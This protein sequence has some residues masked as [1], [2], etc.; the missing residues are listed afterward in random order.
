MRVFGP[1]AASRGRACGESRKAR[2]V[3]GIGA[4]PRQ[5]RLRYVLSAAKDGSRAPRRKTTTVYVVQYEPD[6]HHDI[7]LDQADGE[8]PTLAA[9]RRY[10]TTDDPAPLRIVRRRETVIEPPARPH[11]PVIHMRQ[12]RNEAVTV[13]TVHLTVYHNHERLL[14][15]YADGHRLHAVTSHTLDIHPVVDLDETIDAVAEWAWRTFNADL[16][17]LQNDRIDSRGETTFFAAAVYRLLGNR[18]L[19]AGDILHLHIADR[20]IWLACHP[21]VWRPITEPTNPHVPRPDR[22]ERLRAHHPDTRHR[23]AVGDHV[24]P[25]RPAQLIGSGHAASAARTP[26]SVGRPD[27]I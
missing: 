4:C 12:T 17:M 18:S 24:A 1:G 27:R 26:P 16:D 11:P 2:R 3:V 25:R 5:L 21:Y 14:Q 15:P 6:E 13:P 23:P 7:W 9:A 20:H 19:S 22:R 10:R 8:H